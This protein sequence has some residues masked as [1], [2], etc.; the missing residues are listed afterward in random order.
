MNRIKKFADRTMKI[1]KGMETDRWGYIAKGEMRLPN[2]EGWLISFIGKSKN[3]VP[4]NI[5][6]MWA[7]FYRHTYLHKKGNF[8]T[9]F[10][11]PIVTLFSWIVIYTQ[12]GRYKSTVVIIWNVNVPTFTI[13]IIIVVNYHHSF[14]RES[15]HMRKKWMLV[16]VVKIEN[17]EF[18]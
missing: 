16:F 11:P 18:S 2:Q 9:E 1:L 17:Q 15:R 12:L 3:H 14:P 4:L 5:F 7:T 6:A 10:L 8:L 13:T